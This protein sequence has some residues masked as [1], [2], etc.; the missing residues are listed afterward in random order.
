MRSAIVTGGGSGIGRAAA[1]ALA[2]DGLAVTVADADL[3]AA[4]AVVADIEQRGHTARAALVDVTSRE[5]LAEAVASTVS[6]FGPLVAGVNSAGIQGDLAPVTECTQENWQRTL[7]VNLTG[8]FLAMQAEIEA[9]LHSGGGAIVNLASNFGLV[10]KPRIPAY[11]ASKHGV[12][13]LTKAAALDYA[14]HGIRVNAVCP[15]PVDTPLLT[16]IAEEAGPRGTAMRAEVEASVPL[17][18]IGRPD[19]VG[20]AIAFLCSDAA[21]FVTGTAMPVDGGF[22]VG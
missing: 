5:A 21:S 1:L 10:G 15:G 3:D 7:A 2:A 20:R 12:V 22:V 8:T 19:E 17:G 16:R 14:S 18:R 6:A 11:C 4:K 13:G 9:M